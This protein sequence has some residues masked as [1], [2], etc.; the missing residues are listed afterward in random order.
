MVVTPVE[1]NDMPKCL[2]GRPVRLGGRP[3]DTRRR[4]SVKNSG[5]AVEMVKMTLA[6]G[7]PR[8]VTLPGGGGGGGGIGIGKMTGRQGRRRHGDEVVAALPPSVVP[9]SINTMLAAAPAAAGS[10]HIGMGMGPYLPSL[11]G[12]LTL[13]VLVVGQLII[14]GKVLGISGAVKGIVEGDRSPWRVLFVSGLVLGG[15]VMKMGLY[16]EAFGAGIASVAVS[17]MAAAGLLVGTGTSLGNGCTS[18]HGICGNARLSV[19]SFIST[20]TFMFF[21]AVAA[22]VLG[23]A[24]LEGVGPGLVVAAPPDP[25]V[26]SKAVGLLVS[27]V[28]FVGSLSAAAHVIKA[29]KEPTE[30]DARLAMRLQDVAEFGIGFFFALGLGIS[31]MTKPEKVSSFLSV[32]AGTFDPSLIFV[33]GGALLVALPG[34]QLVLRTQIMDQPLCCSTF[35]LPTNR[36]INVQLLVGSMMFGLGWGTAGLCPGPGLVSLASLQ[37]QNVV[38][39]G[40]MLVGMAVTKMIQKMKMQTASSGG[41]SS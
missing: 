15:V 9:C 22:A 34:Y 6:T 33:M 36:E 7:G 32:F 29:K 3:K 30:G 37:A 35:S 4:R 38:F 8:L 19:R 13:G 16:P 18:G 28:A 12:G 10:T 23:T 31:G 11:L 21:G 40:S 24:S 25:A 17:R 14:S 20:L 27:A 1:K 41:V 2:N 26:M 5:G 39:V